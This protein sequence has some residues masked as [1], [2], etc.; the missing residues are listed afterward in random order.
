MASG[1]NTDD[2]IK[3][4][5]E[6]EARPIV[7]WE[8]EKYLYNKRKEALRELKSRIETVNA[9]ARDL[10][11]FRASYRDKKAVSADSGVLDAVAG[12]NAQNGKHSIE[13]ME[14]ASTHKLSTDS[15]K[16]DDAVPAGKF[17]LEV[18]GTSKTIRF[19]GGT[20]KS[21]QAQIESEAAGIVSS[22]YVNTV[23]DSHIMTL[24]SLT[25][26]KKGE[27]KITGDRDLLYGIGLIKGVKDQEKDRVAVVFDGKYF[28]SYTGSQKPGEETGALEVGKEGKDVEVKGSL[29]RE[30]V[31]PVQVDVK[32]STMLEFNASYKE[33]EE[34]K[35]DE[36]LPYRL[37]LGP[38]EKT[39]IKG[40]ELNSYNI[41]RIR[42]LEKKPPKTPVT[43]VMGIGVVS[44]GKDGRYE[45][46]YPVDR[47]FSGKMEIPVGRDFENRRIG[48]IIF[49]ANTG[50]AKFAD[51]ALFT[52]VEGTGLLDPKNEV[53]RAGDAKIKVDGI[54][55]VRDRNE[56][57]NDIVKGLTL[58]LHRESKKPVTLS[59]EPDI[60]KAAESIKKF[61]EAYNRYLEF[62]REIV[63]AEKSA[64]PGEFKKSRAKTGLF[65]GDMTILRL[66]NTLKETVSN[67]YPSRTE[68]PIKIISQMGVSTGEINAPWES[69]RMG[70]LVV[71]EA[72]LAETIRENPEGVEQF[73]GSDTDGDNRI[74]NGMAYGVETVLKPYVRSGQS[75]I[76]SKIAMEDNNIKMADEKIERRQEH[77]KKYEEKL[78][79]KFATMEKSLSG[80]KAQQNWLKNQMKGAE[81]SSDK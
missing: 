58:N 11:G 21:L 50:T 16:K 20:L 62:N 23:H 26:G 79:Q 56:G 25:P 60:E 45:K 13:V 64:K 70:K 75:I 30:Y 5:I 33:P 52:P 47:K 55:V 22:S 76:T 31:L 44:E 49:Y 48:K 72:K 34:S 24:E 73:F 29:W 10:Y 67:A 38:E 54:E 36:T 32:K 51:A 12:K 68:K 71:D 1:L 2:I 18:N 6:V 7:Q 27:I 63:K 69:I 15:L 17:T 57:L 77:L 14:L 28:V 53:R 41:S 42:P 8:E 43:D 59:V 74:D 65:M 80:A 78:R 46:L 61:V 66:E 35:E 9:A 37:E 40:I 81:G 3:K 4:L 39:V 19:R